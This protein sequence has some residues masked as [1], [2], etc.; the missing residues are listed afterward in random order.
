MLQR[1]LANIVKVNS[2]V[3]GGN[4]IRLEVV[5]NATC[6]HW[7][8]VCE[9]TAVVEAEAEDGVARIQQ[10]QVHRHVR[11]CTRVRLH[12]RMVCSEQF[13][14]TRNCQCFDDVHIDVAAVVAL[15]G[16]P[17]AVLVRQN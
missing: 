12:V 8:T 4:A 15:T 6:V 10:T 13:L 16:V 3:T 7:R 1:Q 17:L 9:V 5:Q 14:H 11:T 2:F